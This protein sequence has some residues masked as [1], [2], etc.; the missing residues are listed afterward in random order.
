M[1]IASKTK[2]RIVNYVSSEEM[3]ALKVAARNAGL[4][5]PSQIVGAWF[6]QKLANQ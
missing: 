6:R 1:K 4:R 3:K 5:T 2:P